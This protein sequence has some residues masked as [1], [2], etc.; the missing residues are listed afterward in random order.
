MSNI[1]K[2]I[3]LGFTLVCV[4][5]LIVFCIQIIVF[6]RGVTPIEA[7][8]GITGGAQQGDEDG[9]SDPDASGDGSGDV[10][11]DGGA[12]GI[13]PAPIT[14]RPPPQGMRYSWLVT[15][16]NRLVAYAR[17]ELFEFTESDRERIFTYTGIGNATLEI[18]FTMIPPQGVAAH[19]ENILNNNSGGNNAEYVGEDLIRGSVLNG[20]YA[21]IRFGGEVHEAWIHMLQGSDLALLFLVNYT[22][23]QQ[24]E[25]LNEI[26]SSLDIE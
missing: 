12:D 3:L 7:G 22:N 20:Y 14:P 5:A 18:S 26:L 25:A 10:N 11:G 1:I 13:T 4:V 15:E 2:N 9:A 6:N 8:T 19:L 21:S 16:D 17:E 23:E 24:L